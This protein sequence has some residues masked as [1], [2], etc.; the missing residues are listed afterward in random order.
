M[1][2]AVC[3]QPSLAARNDIQAKEGNTVLVLSWTAPEALA[4]A[5][6]LHSAL[7][8]QPSVLYLPPAQCSQHLRANISNFSAM[9]I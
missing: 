1:M 5:L 9:H 2:K 3:L 6:Q 4:V 8:A 7:P